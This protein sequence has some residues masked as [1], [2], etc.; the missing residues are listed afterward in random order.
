MCLTGSLEPDGMRPAKAKQFAELL[1]D[2]AAIP[3]QFAK[4]QVVKDVYFADEHCK[5]YYFCLLVLE[6]LHY[7]SAYSQSVWNRLSLGLCA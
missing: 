3:Y 7:V 1:N 2:M 4:D 6:S 5:T